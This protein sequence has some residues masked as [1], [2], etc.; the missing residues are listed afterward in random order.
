MLYV[1][2]LVWRAV[3]DAWFACGLLKDVAKSLG[4]LATWLSSCDG[5]WD[6]VDEVSP[7]NPFHSYQLTQKQPQARLSAQNNQESARA[8]RI[9]G[10]AIIA[11]VANPS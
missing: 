11:A 3:F 4:S 8:L 2:R 10:F 7:T 5:K 9:C 6:Q 1:L